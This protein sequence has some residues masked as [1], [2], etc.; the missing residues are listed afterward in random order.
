M[1]RISKFDQKKF[2]LQSIPTMNNLFSFIEYF[3]SRATP[4]QT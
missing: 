1:K 2:D 4:Q 3:Y